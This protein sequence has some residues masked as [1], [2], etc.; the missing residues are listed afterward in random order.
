[1]LKDFEKKLEFN[2]FKK[3]SFD[4]T[5]TDSNIIEFYLALN[6]YICSIDQRKLG[7]VVIPVKGKAK[8]KE[9][10]AALLKNI[11][12][13]TVSTKTH[14]V[15]VR[16]IKQ[17]EGEVYKILMDYSSKRTVEITSNSSKSFQIKGIK[18]SIAQAI[19]N[20]LKK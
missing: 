8:E 18:T 16:T 1:M 20:S 13:T 7:E 10:I 6:P 11:P 12:H 19:A 2:N 3:E 5:G 4:I 9:V 15:I 14:D 17:H